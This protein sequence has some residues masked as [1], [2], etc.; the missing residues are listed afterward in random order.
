MPWAPSPVVWLEDPPV[1][2]LAAVLV[3]P[4]AAGEAGGGRE[5]KDRSQSHSKRSAF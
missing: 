4:R 1:P 3:S 5:L 2:A